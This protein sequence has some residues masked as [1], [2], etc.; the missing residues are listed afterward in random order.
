MDSVDDDDSVDLL[1]P[2]HEDAVVLGA[3]PPLLLTAARHP[4]LVSLA[5]CLENTPTHDIR[6]LGPRNRGRGS[7]SISRKLEKIS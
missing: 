5:L 7:V 3:D 2:L 6:L 1:L 4:G